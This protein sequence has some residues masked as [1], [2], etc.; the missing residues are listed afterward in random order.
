MPCTWYCTEG[1]ESAEK[2]EHLPT[3]APG[4]QCVF[5]YDAS[6]GDPRYNWTGDGPPPRRWR[7]A[8]GTM[9]YRSFADYC[10]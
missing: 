3:R 2:C 10:G 8:D 7:A 9:V 1:C 4:E 5:T 6:V